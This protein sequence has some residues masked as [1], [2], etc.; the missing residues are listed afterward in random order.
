MRVDFN[1]ELSGKKVEY[2]IK[3]E[4]HVKEPKEQV[5]V[6]LEKFFPFKE[7][8][9]KAKINGE[10][11]EVAFQQELPQGFD[12][13]KKAF[14]KVITESVKGIKKVKF[15]EE[16]AKEKEAPQEKKESKNE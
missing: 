3:I 12:I 13:L 15:M 4:K 14:A 8:S 9:P 1:S 2:D 16:F 6:F 5:D 10:E 11:L 7:K